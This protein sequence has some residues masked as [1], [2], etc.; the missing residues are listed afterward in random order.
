MHYLTKD[1]QTGYTTMKPE[2]SLG[3]IN[4]YEYT[5]LDQPDIKASIVKINAKSR[6][7]KKLSNL[8]DFVVGQ[9]YSEKRQMILYQ[10]EIKRSHLAARVLP[11][12]RRVLFRTTSCFDRPPNGKSQ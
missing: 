10:S 9:F 2:N 4:I 8:N 11:Q 6:K 3:N 12:K 7:M 1:T 5:H